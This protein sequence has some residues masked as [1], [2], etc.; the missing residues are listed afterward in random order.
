[1]KSTPGRI[2]PNALTVMEITEL[3]RGDSE[4]QEAIL[5]LSRCNADIGLEVSMTAFSRLQ[6]IA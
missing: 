2:L 4:I 5:A 1:M 6:M 3:N